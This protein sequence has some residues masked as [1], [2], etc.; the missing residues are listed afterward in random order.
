MEAFVRKKVIL[1]GKNS[2]TLRIISRLSAHGYVR[3]LVISDQTNI[4]W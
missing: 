3:Q 1:L 2:N 4:F